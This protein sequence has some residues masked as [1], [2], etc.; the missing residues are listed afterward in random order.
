MSASVKRREKTRLEKFVAVVKS[1]RE[2]QG[3]MRTLLG[4][5]LLQE[6]VDLRL[7]WPEAVAIFGRSQGTIEKAC[8]F[9]RVRRPT[10]HI[11]W[12]D[13]AIAAVE[14]HA[15]KIPQL[16]N[17]RELSACFREMR[18]AVNE[19]LQKNGFPQKS[20]N[21]IKCFFRSSEFYK[22]P[23]EF[24]YITW[25][26][27]ARKLLKRFYK[28]SFKS[29]TKGES[30]AL[31]KEMMVALNAVFAQEGLPPRSLGAVRQFAH[32]KGIEWGWH[33][34]QYPSSETLAQKERH[35]EEL[36]KF[37]AERKDPGFWKP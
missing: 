28:R 33:N 16:K 2:N 7:N 21:A 3:F 6:L 4:M 10:Y 20:M 14:E 31:S 1:V 25:S 30:V 5:E 11:S 19:A 32:K 18:V 12:P 9:H 29:R 23:Y 8:S 34:G 15:E 27:E 13:E 26:T 36:A 24:E 22:G 37:V 35:N 17:N